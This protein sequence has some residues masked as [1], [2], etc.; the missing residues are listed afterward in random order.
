MATIKK[1]VVKRAVKKVAPK[2]KVTAKQKMMADKT[3]SKIPKTAKEK[4]MWI[5]A[6]RLVA[7]ETGRYKEDE[8]PWGLVNHIYEAEKKAQKVIK[9]KE[10]RKTKESKA[11]R[12]Y[13]TKAKPK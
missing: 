9:P 11:V 12:K 10:I 7:K 13:K 6:R 3:G 5:Q 1:K 2:K 8:I 4:K